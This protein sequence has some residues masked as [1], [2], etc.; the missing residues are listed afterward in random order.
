MVSPDLHESWCGA[1]ACIVER[2]V[3]S[4]GPRG[5]TALPR[6]MEMRKSHWNSVPH[7]PHYGLWGK[8]YRII[9]AWL[10]TCLY[11]KAFY[12]TPGFLIFTILL[13]V[14]PLTMYPAAAKMTGKLEAFAQEARKPFQSRNDF[15]TFLRTDGENSEYGSRWS[16]KDLDPTLPVQRH[17]RW[18][19][20]TLY[21]AGSA[22]GIT[23]WNVAA[24]LIAVGLV[25]V[26]WEH[27]F[28]ARSN[29]ITDMET[30]LRV[31]RHWFSSYWA[32]CRWSCETRCHVSYWIVSFWS[33]S[34]CNAG[35]LIIS[36]SCSLQRCN[37]HVW[38]ILLCFHKSNCQ[39]CLVSS[40]Y[41]IWFYLCIE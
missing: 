30:S 38:L 7:I 13:S 14:S 1:H 15:I 32:C 24:S 39:L 33:Y 2:R 29:W 22:F 3:C 6:C 25:S 17:W 5:A 20:L 23:G 18:Y 11:R 19:S 10:F 27:V 41:Y 35:H 4:V 31:L 21:W 28:Q 36:Q 40:Q 8:K 26:L 34:Y 9:W 37:G 16:N 12:L